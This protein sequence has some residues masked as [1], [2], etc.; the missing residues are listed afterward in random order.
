[1]VFVAQGR[2]VKV[3]KGGGAKCQPFPQILAFRC[4]KVRFGNTALLEITDTT[5]FVAVLLSPTC[6]LRHGGVTA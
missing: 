1:M 4:K 6:C 3:D 5:R 2:V